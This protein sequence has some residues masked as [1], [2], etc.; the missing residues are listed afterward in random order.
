MKQTHTLEEMEEREV[1]KEG[2]RGGERGGRNWEAVLN[3]KV[4]LGVA[5]GALLTHLGGT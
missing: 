2:K 3:Q 5:D 4:Q 1:E